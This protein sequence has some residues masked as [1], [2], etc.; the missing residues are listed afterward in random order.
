MRIGTQFFGEVDS[1]GAESIKT[2]FFI[3]GMPLFPLES[4]Y[5][6][7]SSY[8]SVDGFPLS[9]HNKSVL[10]TYLFWWLSLPLV[11]IGGLFIFIEK[12]IQYLLPVV[13][14]VLVWFVVNR[15]AQLSRAEKR[16]R[17]V[18]KNIAGVGAPPELLPQSFVQQ[19]LL[20][21]E[22]RWNAKNS[23]SS[24]K[25]W[26]NLA[27]IDDLELDSL[28]LLFCLAS[29]SEKFDLASNIMQRIETETDAHRNFDDSLLS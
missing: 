25:D 16:R 28:L 2:K 19:T 26:R 7:S 22:D 20:K 11:L 4:Y 14:G 21:L 8:K 23:D 5:C 13:F 9:L 17:T 18:L 29:Y 12:E 6:L 1:I 27:F 10:V 3:L 15:L 24:Q